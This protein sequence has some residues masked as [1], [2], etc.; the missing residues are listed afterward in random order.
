VDLAAVAA[1]LIQIQE[2]IY[3]ALPVLLGKEML[4]AQ[5]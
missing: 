5:D 4:A 3:R 2:W 1:Q